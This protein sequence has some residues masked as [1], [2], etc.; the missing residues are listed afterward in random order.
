[1]R[2]QRRKPDNEK[3]MATDPPPGLLLIA[4]DASHEAESALAQ[5]REVAEL[6]NNEEYIRALGAFEG[7]ED[8]VHYVGCVLSRFARVIGLRR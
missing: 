1:M 7:L 6:L 5:L 8:R 4:E 2:S 3:Y